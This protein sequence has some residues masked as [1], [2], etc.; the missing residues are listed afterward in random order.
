[1]LVVRASNTGI[2]DWD[3]LKRTVYYSARLKEILGYPADAD[4][5][6]WP[7]YWELVHPEDRPRVE[8]RFREHIIQERAER[9]HE[10]IQYRLRRRDGSYVWI[11]AFGAS[12]RDE[13]G[14][15]RRFIASITDISVR[16]AQEEALITERARLNLVVEAQQVGIVDWD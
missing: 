10:I 8:A 16:R 13:K 3:G 12:V 9:L 5:S 2:L 14:F 11:E 1:E 4:E 7:D 15:A 6:S